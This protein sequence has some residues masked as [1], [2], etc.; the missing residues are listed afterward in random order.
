MEELTRAFYEERF[1]KIFLRQKYLAFQDFF[2]DFMSK[3]Y[4]SDFIPVKPWGKVGDRKCDGY[5]KSKRMLFQVYAPNEI[6]ATEAINKIEGDFHGALPYWRDYFDTWVFVHNSRQ[7]LNPDIV[8][9]LLSLEEE[10][11][12]VRILHWGYEEIK[13]ELFLLNENDLIALLGYAPTN[14]GMNELR[15]E[16]LRGSFS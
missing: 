10:S 15:F 4:V 11:K 1:E 9:K 13:Q 3:R 12:S 8:R 14:R 7:G 6:S 16:Q 2:S 5:L